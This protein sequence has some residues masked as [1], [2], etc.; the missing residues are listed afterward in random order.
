[1]K[2]IDFVVLWVDGNDPNWLAEKKEYSPLS[3][4]DSNTASRFRDWGL[5]KYWF[6]SIESFAPWVRRIHFVTWGHLPPFLNTEHPKL[7]IVNHRD[8]LPERY[9]P[10]YSSHCLEMN[11][12]RIE[13]LSDCFV[14]FNDDMFLTKPLQPEYY[15][16]NGKPCTYFGE[17]PIGFIGKLE[18]WQWASINNLCIINKYINKAETEKKNRG[19]FIN[20]SYKLSDNLRSQLLLHVCKNYFTGFKNFHCPVAYLKSTFGYL[21]DIEN[22]ILENTS[23]H[24]FR[25]KADVNQWLALWWQIANGEFIPQRI[26]SR[27][28]S[29]TKEQEKQICYAIENQQYDTICINDTEAP[30]AELVYGSIRDSFQ[31]AFPNKSEFEK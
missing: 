12:H 11:L 26:N 14:Y 31:K 9:L 4:D 20:R 30:E 6:R 8:Y 27:V 25:D 19:K 17:V 23:M 21:W 29:S 24:K 15:F 13:D 5:M 1:M 16:R 10:T 18:V 7:H 2:D 3:V 22:D 28:F